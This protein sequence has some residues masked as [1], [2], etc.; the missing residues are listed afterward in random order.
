MMMLKQF[1]ILID[2]IGGGLLFLKDMTRSAWR[3]GVSS[4]LI[5]LQIWRVTIQSLSTTALAGFF[6]GAIMTVQFTLQVKAFGA[7]GYLGGLATSGTV[8]EVGPLLIAFM[9]SGK[10]GAF[11]S[12]ELGT[13]RVT[14]QIDAIRCLGADPFQEIILPRF[15]GIVVS[16]FFL[17]TAGLFMSIAGGLLMGV[18]FSGITA[19]EYLRHIPTIVNPLSIGSG[20]FKCIVFALVLASICTY[21]GYTASGGAKGV[22]RAVVSTA[23]STMVGLV[24]A[25]WLTT[26]IG[27]TFTQIMIGR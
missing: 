5:F 2:E 23:V 16:S 14:E 17:L 26:L 4:Q 11:T 12:A 21:K 19:D 10:V 25:D 9:L 8:R 24:V 6:V 3:G 27:D 20:I 1:R 22:G 7:L 13:M 18:Y 15:V